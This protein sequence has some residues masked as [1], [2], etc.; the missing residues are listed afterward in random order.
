MLAPED[1]EMSIGSDAG[2][3]HASHAASM[4][5]A[6]YAAARIRV[7]DMGPWMKP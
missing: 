7:M 2:M 1:A 5:N 3:T 4:D 6:K